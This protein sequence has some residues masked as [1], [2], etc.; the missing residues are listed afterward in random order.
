MNIIEIL[1]FTLVIAF[2]VV[3]VSLFEPETLYG[4]LFIF[5]AG[6]TIFVAIYLLIMNKLFNVPKLPPCKKN[7]CKVNDYNE[8]WQDAEGIYYKCACGDRYLLTKEDKFHIITGNNEVITYM[9]RY[10]T[11]GPWRPI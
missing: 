4:T 8:E 9:R 6:C 5:I 1:L 11:G 2:G 7:K 10:Y 3:I